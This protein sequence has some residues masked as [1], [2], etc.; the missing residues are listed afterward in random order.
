MAILP[1]GLIDRDNFGGFIPAGLS[2]WCA[3]RRP[4]HC[5]WVES[6]YTNTGSLD[7][8]GVDPCGLPATPT[9]SDTEST[10][11]ASHL[12]HQRIGSEFSAGEAYEFDIAGDFGMP[13]QRAEWTT[14]W[15]QGDWRVSARTIGIGKQDREEETLIG[16]YVTHDLQIAWTFSPGSTLAIGA[17]N[18]AD[19]F[20]SWIQAEDPALER[21]PLQRPGRT[22]TWEPTFKF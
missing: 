21:L 19:R 14:H 22:P 20:P 16:T 8:D 17:T 5:C 9:T 12:L 11:Q 1:Q 15:T 2:V 4:V 3:T 18:L 13:E 6:G 7:T 10:L